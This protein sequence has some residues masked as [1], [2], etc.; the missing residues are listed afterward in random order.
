MEP[1]FPTGLTGELT[2]SKTAKGAGA[3]PSPAT[4]DPA[5]P[6]LVTTVQ[7]KTSTHLKALPKKDDPSDEAVRD[8]RRAQRQDERWSNR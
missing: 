5:L 2:M 8:I 1:N 3:T 6:A 7:P 4:S